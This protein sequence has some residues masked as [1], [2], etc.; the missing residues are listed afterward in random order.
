M[1]CGITILFYNCRIITEINNLWLSFS[2]FFNRFVLDDQYTSSLGTKF[3]IK[4]SAPEVI[5][6]SRFSS[7][8]D[9][10]SFGEYSTIN[11]YLKCM[12]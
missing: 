10:W 8:S 2:I 3:P 7:K 1:A 12:R 5:K 9:V 11:T 4:W 6:Y